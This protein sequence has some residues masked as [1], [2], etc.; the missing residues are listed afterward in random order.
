MYYYI[1]INTYVFHLVIYTSS[2]WSIDVSSPWLSKVFPSPRA[3]L[4]SGQRLRD[5]TGDHRHSRSQGNPGKSAPE[6]FIEIYFVIQCKHTTHRHDTNMYTGRV[7][8]GTPELKDKPYSP[9]E[10][11]RLGLDQSLHTH[12]F[13][14]LVYIRWMYMALKLSWTSEENTSV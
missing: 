5:T 11:A 4:L 7:T 8:N 9:R 2:E 1:Y 10:R 13:S 14:V 3:G 6:L 12:Y